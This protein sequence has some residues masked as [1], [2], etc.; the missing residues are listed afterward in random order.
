MISGVTNRV[1]N[2]GSRIED[3]VRIISAL[4]KKR[5]DR[6]V[7]PTRMIPAQR[8]LAAHVAQVLRHRFEPGDAFFHSRVS[9]E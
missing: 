8:A 4:G 5:G 3:R 6:P 2:G 9:A 1:E 7:A